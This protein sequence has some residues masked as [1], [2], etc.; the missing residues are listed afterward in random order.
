MRNPYWEHKALV[1]ITRVAGRCEFFN[2]DDVDAEIEAMQMPPVHD[3]RALGPVMKRA[4]SLG[5]I[6][7]TDSFT[8]SV[9]RVSHACPRRMWKSNVF[10]ELANVQHAV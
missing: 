9:R 10:A 4:A 5:Y 2:S 7:A 1:A 8:T 3:K 6:R